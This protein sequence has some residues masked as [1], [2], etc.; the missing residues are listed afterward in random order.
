MQLRVRLR[1]RLRVQLR[2]RLRVRLRVQVRLQPRVRL[3]VH[4]RCRCPNS[5]RCLSKECGSYD[6]ARTMA[7]SCY[8]TPTR[9]P[10]AS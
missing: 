2:V 1:V 7:S 3:R 9:L 6:F 4:L 5:L 8:D 10:M